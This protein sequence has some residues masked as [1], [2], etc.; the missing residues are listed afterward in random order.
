MR[1]IT[2][3]G[4]LVCLSCGIPLELH[5]SNGHNPAEYLVERDEQ[6]AAA[7]SPA[8]KGEGRRQA[9][10][11]PAPESVCR[12]GSTFMH[13]RKRGRRHALCPSCR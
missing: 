10:E 3:Q 1:Y 6:T 5:C 9:R 2:R 8:P 12:C 13:E 11:K 4:P 7:M